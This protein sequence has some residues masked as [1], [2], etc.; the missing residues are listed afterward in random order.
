MKFTVTKEDADIWENLEHLWQSWSVDLKVDNLT[1]FEIALAALEEGYVTD[2]KFR[3]DHG[4]WEEV[5]FADRETYTF[6][7]IKYS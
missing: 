1:A 5:T 3:Q 2:I 7:C 6:L 4:G